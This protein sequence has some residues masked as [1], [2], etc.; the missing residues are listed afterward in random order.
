MKCRTL[1][2]MATVALSSLSLSA[3][4]Y[5]GIEYEAV[6]G[7]TAK[8]S[9]GVN[10]T[11][12]VVIPETVYDGE[13][14]YT[15]TELAKSCFRSAQV[16]SV[17]LPSTV[18]KIGSSAFNS[19]TVETVV[20]NE[21]VTSIPLNTFYACANLKEI[22]LPTSLKSIGTLA[23]YQCVALKSVNIPEG[24]TLIDDCAFK[25]C[26]SL[27]SVKLPST[28]T[29]YY[30][31]TFSTCTSLKSITI[32]EGV[33]AIPESFCYMCLSLEEIN[34]PSTLTIIKNGAFT[35]CESL[36]E[37][38]L[39][40]SCAT[41]KKRAFANCNSLTNVVL[42][43][44]VVTLE[45]DVF[46]E[47]INMRSITLSSTVDVLGFGSLGCWELLPDN[48]YRWVFSDIYCNGDVPPHF[49]Y[50]DY[51]RPEP[52]FF[53]L[54]NFSN[55]QKSAFYNSITI[56]VPDEAIDAYKNADIWKNFPNIVGSL[57]GVNTTFASPAPSVKCMAGN[58]EIDGLAQGDVVS[59]Y[60]TDGK[61]VYSTMAS[62]PSAT[63]N[64]LPSGILI[65]KA[66]ST[67]SKVLVK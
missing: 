16:K 46:Y 50:D 51:A 58:V 12:D 5:N 55:A 9:S 15:V 6:S 25:E 19:S 31:Q 30:E 11:G 59:I 29:K 35:N 61:Q 65:V 66:G 49:E 52:D 60:T 2:F 23:F 26:T 36:K 56:H 8:V 37:L 32:P 14:P 38:N 20:L 33:T 42:P 54:E 24:V 4:N 62:A 67:A 40:A 17:T 44:G 43:E 27:E 21:G 10:A 34:F 57:T 39:P 45:S 13:T 41:I 18:T 53:S 28:C 48:T 47:C 7:S 3:F 22:T 63:I 1:L 64:N